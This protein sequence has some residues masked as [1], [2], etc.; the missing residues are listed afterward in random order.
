LETSVLDRF[1]APLCDA[2]TGRDDAQATLDLLD[3]A[4]LFLVSLDD[5]REWYRYHHLFSSM[6]NSRLRQQHP[7]RVTDLH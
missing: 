5:K 1:C 3:N 7:E 6:L 2:V 4:N